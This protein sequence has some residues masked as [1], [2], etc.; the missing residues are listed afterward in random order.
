M[1]TNERVWPDVAIPPGETLAEILEGQGI[2]QAELARRAGRP[3]QVISEIIKGKKEITPETALE[4]ERVLGVP[5]HVWVRMEADFRMT[6]ARLDESERLKAEIHLLKEYPYR[7]MARWGWVPMVKD[8]V[9][10]VRILQRFFG[11]ASLNHVA[12]PDVA[13][14]WRKSK[15]VKL[16]PA[17]LK[18]WLRQGEIMAEAVETGAFDPDGLTEMLPIL[19]ALTLEPPQESV[20]KAFRILAERGVAMVLLP[21][22][23]GT[24]AHG[25]ARW[26]GQ[27]ALMQLSIR[28]RWA[29][30]FWFTFFH[31]L[32][33]ILKHGRRNVFLEG[34]P[35][36]DQREDE[37]DFFAAQ[38]LIPTSA[39]RSFLNRASFSAA[40]VCEFASQVGIDRGIVVGRLHHDH[41]IHPSQLNQLRTRYQWAGEE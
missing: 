9:A 21:H 41:Q 23:P 20:P 3:P 36:K 19:R 30:V 22:L 18:A 7:E 26:F 1:V 28:Y 10:R 14:T 39:Y 12:M 16:S 4:F 27:K 15:R 35:V 34:L 24:G 17:A 37:A 2:T 40:T 38:A 13:T 32:A 25:A 5:A 6:K 31:E 11:V 29:D 33:H 8:A